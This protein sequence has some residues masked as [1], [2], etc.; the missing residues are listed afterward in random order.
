MVSFFHL[1]NRKRQV[2]PIS[3]AEIANHPCYNNNYQTVMNIP[4]LR[5]NGS[6]NIGGSK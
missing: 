6:S 1:N 3:F 5:I 4:F 2:C